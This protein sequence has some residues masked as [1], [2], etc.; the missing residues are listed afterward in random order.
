MLS[1]AEFIQYSLELNLFFARIMK[2]HSIFIE[3]GFMPRDANLAQQ[4]DCFKTQ[5]EALLADTIALA[6]GVISPDS[7]MSGEFVTQYTMEA[8][9][10]SQFYT[11]I[12]IDSR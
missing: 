2:E 12:Q 9:R 8:E 3:G 1:S 4:A 6:N 7:A 11:G 5:F 10:A